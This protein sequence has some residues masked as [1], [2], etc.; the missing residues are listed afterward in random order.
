MAISKRMQGFMGRWALR[1][2]PI[3]RPGLD[4]ID[5]RA[6]CTQCKT[7]SWYDHDS[8][9]AQFEMNEQYLCKECRPSSSIQVALCQSIPYGVL[10]VV[11]EVCPPKKVRDIMWKF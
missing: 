1:K 11:M 5:P 2:D 4:F 10:S 7:G 6:V 9:D 8:K 3:W